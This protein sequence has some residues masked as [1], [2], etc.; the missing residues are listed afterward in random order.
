MTLSMTVITR[1]IHLRPLPYLSK[2]NFRS[3][4]WPIY[5][6]KC[7]IKVRQFTAN[8]HQR[9]S[10]KN[11][12]TS[13][14]N[15]YTLP[16]SLTLSRILSCPILGWSI[17]DGNYHL[18]TGLL[19]YAGL[20]DWVGMICRPCV[21]LKDGSLCFFVY[22]ARRVSGTSVQHVLCSWNYP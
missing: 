4:P 17:L 8:S 5:I 14:E 9:R 19:F 12:S 11:K 6:N 20:T 1:S 7:T 10:Q 21:F 22:Q 15:I 16:N 3:R 2:I 18:S 13:R